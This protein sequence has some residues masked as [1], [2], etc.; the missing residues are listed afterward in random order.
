ML[1]QPECE[2]LFRKRAA[3]SPAAGRD[4]RGFERFLR[5]AERSGQHSRE[6]RRHR[7]EH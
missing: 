3:E 2:F 5:R 7:R 6:S 1:R 4:K